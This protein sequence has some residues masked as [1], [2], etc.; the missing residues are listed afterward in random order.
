MRRPTFLNLEDGRLSYTAGHDL[1]VAKIFM[2][3][4]HQEECYLT[5]IVV[6]VELQD[7]VSDG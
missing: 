4:Q 3:N 5:W 1:D 7:E 6:E 2:R